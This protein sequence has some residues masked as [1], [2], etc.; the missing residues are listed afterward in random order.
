MDTRELRISFQRSGEDLFVQA[1]E[2]TNGAQGREP[3]NESSLK[4]VAK[5]LTTGGLASIQARSETELEQ[6]GGTLFEIL[7]RGNLLSFLDA[8]YGNGAQQG[9]IRLRFEFDPEQANLHWLESVPWELLYWGRLQLFPA[10]DRRFSLIRS[11]AVP[12]PAASFSNKG[13]LNCLVAAALPSSDEG[14]RPEIEA[15]AIVD[16]LSAVDGFDVTESPFCG[17][18]TVRNLLVR[19]KAQVFHF[20]GHG[21]RKPTSEGM[22]FGL[23]FEDRFAREARMSARACAELLKDTDVRLVVLNACIS[24][25]ESLQRSGEPFHGV[26]QR[27]VRVGLPAVLAM[28]YPIGD[29]VGASFAGA[30]YQGIAQ[31]DDLELALTEARLSLKRAKS[32][33]HSWFIPALYL[34][35]PGASIFGKQVGRGDPQSPHVTKVPMAQKQSLNVGRIEARNVNLRT[36]D[37]SGDVSPDLLAAFGQLDVETTVDS[38]NAE[39]D[40]NQTGVRFRG[41]QS[42]GDDS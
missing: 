6:L 10:L 26:A 21:Y 25:A 28:R 23:C 39:E 29:R 3:V 33:F 2:A 35:S 24:A 27:L 40:V 32:D 31:G 13:P 15:E 12:V 36:L 16:A 19:N 9:L 22:E 11:L 38:I 8:A 30:L 34:R 42:G 5:E 14:F 4:E 20:L 41:R 7:I 18:D 37:L 17:V 1:R